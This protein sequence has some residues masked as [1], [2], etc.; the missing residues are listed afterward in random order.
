MRQLGPFWAGRVQLRSPEGWTWWQ[1]ADAPGPGWYWWDEAGNCIEPAHEYELQMPTQPVQ[2][3]GDGQGLMR[4]AK[5]KLRLAEFVLQGDWVRVWWDG[6]VAWTVGPASG[7][8]PAR[9]HDK[10]RAGAALIQQAVVQGGGRL[11]DIQPDPQGWR[12]SWSRGGATYHTL[13]DPHLNVL[14]AGFCL[15][16]GDRAYDLTSLVSLV[17]GRESQYADPRVWRGH[18]GW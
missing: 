1:K 5:V 12:V 16:R 8:T 17:E 2:K 4:Q 10:P 18:T 13:V 3:T 14:R 15:S 7:P 9:N 11:V 6:Q